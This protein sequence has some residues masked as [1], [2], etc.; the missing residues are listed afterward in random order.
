MVGGG[1]G[2]CFGCGLIGGADVGML[3]V[4]GRT[5]GEINGLDERGG[6]GMDAKGFDDVVEFLIVVGEV[7]LVVAVVVVVIAIAVFVANGASVVG[8]SSD[9][10]DDV[11]VDVRGEPK[12]LLSVD[13]RNG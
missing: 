10:D 12:G 2:C 6:R 13:K 5:I 4:V 7:A 8:D 11:A 3:F 1:C 9:D